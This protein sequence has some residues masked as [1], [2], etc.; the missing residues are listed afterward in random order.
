MVGLHRALLALF[1]S[2][3]TSQA[4]SVSIDALAN[5]PRI[6]DVKIS[7]GGEYLALRMFKE[8]KHGLVFVDRK[9]TSV[10][11][12]VGFSGKAEV[13]D[14]SWANNE[15]VVMQIYEVSEHDRQPKY[16][17][18]LYAANYDGSKSELIFGVRSGQ[19]QTGS[20]IKRKQSER[21]WADIIDLLPHDDQNIL[22]SSTAMNR[23]QDKR[24]RA[25][26]LDIYK[27]RDSNSFKVS[28]YPKGSFYTDNSGDVRIVKSYKDDQ[29]IHIEAL[30]DKS[31][32][33]VELDESAFGSTFIPV[34]MAED[35]ES[36]YVLDDI[37][38]D[39]VGLY[40]LALDGSSYT[41]VYTDERLDITSLEKTT[42]GNGVF[43]I[44][45]DDGYPK[46]LLFSK[47]HPE[48]QLFRKFLATF[49]GSVLSITSR[50]RDGR[51]WVAKTRSDIDPGSYYL[52]D[53]KEERLQLL[54]KEKDEVNPEE[55]APTEPIAFESHDGREITGYYTA[56]KDRGD[57]VAPLVVLVHGGPRARDYWGFDPGVQV[58]ATQGYSVLQIN[59]RGSDGFGNGFLNAGNRQWGNAVQGDIIAGTRWAIATERAEAGRV[60]I[61]G[62]SF[63]GYSALQS[64]ILEPD[65]YACVIANAG[66]Y[67]LAMMYTEGD[68]E[69][70]YLGKAYLEEA[71]GRDKEELQRY[72]PAANAEKLK[73][74]VLLAHGGKDRRAPYKQAEAMKKAL[75]KHDKHYVAFT[76]KSEG[77]GF[78]DDE[79]RSEYFRATIDFLETHIPG[80]T[81]KAQ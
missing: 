49:P 68:I 15:R 22:I 51:Y 65:L 47:A 54:F 35:G 44:R 66:I 79:N 76:K 32:D 27:G 56:A 52:Y 42:D 1:L 36:M 2:I 63:G 11:G 29:S 38:S 41:T 14:F 62:S 80:A 70:R 13:G 69:Y 8:G 55:L 18:E 28:A 43:A 81:I 61:M 64:A 12:T 10:L 9:E 24:P 71:I 16:Y 20:L 6:V 72:S 31:A 34:A 37:D 46:Y 17:G 23:A 73:A 33:W 7:P 4:F 74:P 67:D 78:Y 25:Q 5:R 30:P 50:T 75:D 59:F 39:K 58:L 48:A 53:D 57:S 60:C 3:F 26:R 77:H 19:M 45:V 21:A 40:N